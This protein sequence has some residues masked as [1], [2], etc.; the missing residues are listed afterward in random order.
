MNRGQ[1]RRNIFLEDQGRQSF[2]D[3]LGDIVRLWKVEIYAY[4]LMDNHF[5]CGAQHK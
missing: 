2:L 3:S 1:W 5:L 4:C